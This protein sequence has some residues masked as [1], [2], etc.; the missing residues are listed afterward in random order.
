[1]FKPFEL[2][3]LVVKSVFFFVKV[4]FLLVGEVPF[5]FLGL[6]W[7]GPEGFLRSLALFLWVGDG[8]GGWFDE[9][10]DFL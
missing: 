9:I 4:W 6:V 5:L 3:L 8:F 1:M 2:V 10:V 7:V